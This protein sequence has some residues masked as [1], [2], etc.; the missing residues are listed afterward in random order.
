MV[1]HSEFEH[2]A[3]RKTW[4]GSVEGWDYGRMDE[5]EEL[6][7]VCKPEVFLDSDDRRLAGQGLGAERLLFACLELAYEP[8]MTSFDSG[9][10]WMV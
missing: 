6:V 8:Q 7:L 1:I 2:V 3:A 5:A 4:A 9:K 10:V